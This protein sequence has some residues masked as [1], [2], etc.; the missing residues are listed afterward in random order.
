MTCV[1]CNGQSCAQRNCVAS[2]FTA[3]VVTISGAASIVRNADCETNFPDLCC[4]LNYGA[5]WLNLLNQLNGTFVAA[6]Q[7]D[8]VFESGGN[9]SDPPP[10][11]H[12]S[13]R[14]TL[15]GS[16]VAP[17]ARLANVSVGIANVFGQD[18][19]YQEFYVIGVTGYACHV[20][21]RCYRLRRRNQPFSQWDYDVALT[22]CGGS[23]HVSLC[24]GATIQQGVATGG[25]A[26]VDC[27]VSNAPGSVLPFLRCGGVANA[28]V[29]RFVG[30]LTVQ[31]V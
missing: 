11:G 4:T 1:C 30:T 12:V 7:S 14:V 26:T 21:P 17:C 19:C 27:A 31:L 2:K 20:P 15:E 24:D 13:A 23:A 8:S 22:T 9:P 29:A 10:L 18:H 28:V 6:R 3:A 16:S 25:Y 5:A